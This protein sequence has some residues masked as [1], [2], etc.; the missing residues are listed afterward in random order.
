MDSVFAHVFEAVR[1]VVRDNQAYFNSADVINHNHG[2]HMLAIFD[3]AV[4]TL[5]DLHP[6]NLAEAMLAAGLAIQKLEGNGSARVYAD[7]LIAFA[8]KLGQREIGQA[9]LIQFVREKTG[10]TRLEQTKGDEQLIEEK[11]I[12]DDRSGQVLKALVEGLSAWKQMNSGVSAKGRN[13]D[14][15]ALFEL[16]IIYLQAKQRGGSNIEVLADA[17]VSASPLNQSAHR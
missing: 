9:E 10:D 17:A 1:Q 2:D 3:L 5:R 8:Q 4:K 16:G 15:G 7:G 11:G 14:M 6:G 12:Q 13:L